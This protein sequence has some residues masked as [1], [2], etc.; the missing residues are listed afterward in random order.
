MIPTTFKTIVRNG[1]RSIQRMPMSGVLVSIFALTCGIAAPASADKLRPAPPGYVKCGT[2]ACHCHHHVCRCCQCRRPVDLVI[3]LDTSGSMTELID[4]ARSRLWDVVNELAAIKPAPILRVGLLT[5]GTPGNSSAKDGWVVR[6]L[7]LTNDL[8]EVYAK[9]MA[10]STSGGDEYVGW[11]LNDAVEKLSWSSD[12]RA[13]KIVF[14]AG[15]ESADQARSS[16]DFRYVAETAQ[17]KRIIINSIYAGNRQQGI[18]EAWHEVARYGK[19]SYSAIDMAEGTY[20]IPT[21]YDDRLS[22]L[23]SELNSTYIAYGR[24]GYESQQRQLLQDKNAEHM[25]AEANASRAAAKATPLYSNSIWD[26]VDASNEDDFDLGEIDAKDLP[27]PMQTMSHEE[28]LA[29]VKKQ[30]DKR[31]DVQLK[32][33]SINADRMR[34]IEEKRKESK[35]GDKQGL[36]DAMLAAL[37]QQALDNGFNFA[38]AENESSTTSDVDKK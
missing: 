30:A 16:Y 4:S 37:R 8:D 11:V 7:D 1:Y 2:C 36:G 22:V 26:L 34:F 32:I 13:L 21:P 10:M 27:E 20:Q 3:C 31:A 35:K 38:D 19:G 5:Y 29:Y 17:A 24:L 25:G 15:N 6:Q 18:N 33:Q 9:M 23:N 28:Q 14:V 12:P